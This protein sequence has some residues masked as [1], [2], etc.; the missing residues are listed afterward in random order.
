VSWLLRSLGLVGSSRQRQAFELARGELMTARVGGE[1]LEIMATTQVVAP[2]V[3]AALE[4]EYAARVADAEERLRQLHAESEE[5]PGEELDRA[6][7]HLLNVEREH[8]LEAH[9]MG[10]M[11]DA[12]RDKLL[13]DV[14]ARLSRSELG[15]GGVI[16]PAG[17]E[18]PPE[19]GAPTRVSRAMLPPNV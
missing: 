18:S 15:T 7:R 14:D 17:T 3:Q 5:L 13:D 16:V 19:S 11:S 8:I 9:R 1:E 6:R 10:A 12:V 4:Q 2:A